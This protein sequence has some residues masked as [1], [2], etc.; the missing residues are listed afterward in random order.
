L[1]NHVHNPALLTVKENIIRLKDG[2]SRVVVFEGFKIRDY[3]Y[4]N[5]VDYFFRED[6]VV[7]LFRCA[8]KQVRFAFSRIKIGT[9]VR[10]T[11]EGSKPNNTKY[12]VESWN[13]EEQKFEEEK[14]TT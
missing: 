4:T 8:Q 10:V 6:D 12:K 9:K 7:K 14:W 1:S 3:A 5:F 2:E 13:D 11:R